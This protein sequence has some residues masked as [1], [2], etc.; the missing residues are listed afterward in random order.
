M[1]VFVPDAMLL[2]MLRM[3]AKSVNII[4]HMHTGIFVKVLMKRQYIY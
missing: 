2:L 1:R 3:G 4:L